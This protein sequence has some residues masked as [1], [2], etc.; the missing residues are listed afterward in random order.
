MPEV[1]EEL[2]F[3]NPDGGVWKQGWDLIVNDS[4]FSRNEK[5]KVFVVTHSHNDPGWIKTFDRYFREQTKNILD[6][7]V[8]K[9]SDDPS[10][11][12]IWAETSYLSAWWETVKDHK[13][14]VKMRRLVESGRLEIVT[15][16]WVM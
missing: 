8:N 14:K 7:I 4:M 3:D 5:L 2:K 11:R 1:Y 13:M 6:N 16:G 9:L 12:F 15:G 10:L